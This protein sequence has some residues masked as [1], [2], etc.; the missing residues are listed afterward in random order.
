MEKLGKSICKV[1]HEKLI[2]RL[3]YYCYLFDDM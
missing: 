2:E 3:T 1:K